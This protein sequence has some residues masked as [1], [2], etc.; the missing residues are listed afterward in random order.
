MLIAWTGGSAPPPSFPRNDSEKV[1]VVVMYL[2]QL[3]DWLG[4]W[5]DWPDSDTA[6]IFWDRAMYDAWA[7]VRPMGE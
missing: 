1:L 6:R 7:T 3:G 2:D 4:F 5:E